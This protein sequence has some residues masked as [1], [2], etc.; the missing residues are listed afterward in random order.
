MP[1]GTGISVSQKNLCVMG[2][3]QSEAGKMLNDR[4]AEVMV[5]DARSSSLAGATRKPE[6]ID[7]T[8][9]DTV[10]LCFCPVF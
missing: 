8:L 1:N 2:G 4:V 7:V 5:W 9:L 10:V 3:L 6:M